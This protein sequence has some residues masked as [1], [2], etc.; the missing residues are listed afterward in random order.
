[1]LCN[2]DADLMILERNEIRRYL[3][4][5]S[6]DRHCLSATGVVHV[7]PMRVWFTPLEAEHV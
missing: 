2:W 5:K 3:V 7:L 4:V 1:M 6:A